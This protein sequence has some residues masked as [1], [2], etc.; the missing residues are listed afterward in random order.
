[1]AGRFP[2]LQGLLQSLGNSIDEVAMVEMNFRV[3]VEGEDLRA[4]ARDFLDRIL[5]GE[6]SP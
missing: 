4:V 3:D 6:S 2:G 1:M 5:A